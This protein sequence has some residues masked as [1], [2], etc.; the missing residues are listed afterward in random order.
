MK[1]S[2]NFDQTDWLIFLLIIKN[3]KKATL[4]NYK[5]PSS[6]SNNRKRQVKKLAFDLA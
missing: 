3:P 4:V 6:I 2:T 1:I 5:A